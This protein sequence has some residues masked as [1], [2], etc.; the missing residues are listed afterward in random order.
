MIETTF[1]VA[2]IAGII[3]FASPCVL[4]LIPGFLAYLSGTAGN[5]KGARMKTFL[6]SVSISL[7]LLASS[8]KSFKIVSF[9]A[10]LKNTIN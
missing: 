3:S 1:I 8:L 7:S 2:F 5:E 6:N 10:R 4:P 9:K